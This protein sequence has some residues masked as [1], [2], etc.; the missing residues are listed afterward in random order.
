LPAGLAISC[1][2]SALLGL[3]GDLRGTLALHWPWPAAVDITGR[4]LGEENDY[5]VEEVADA[6]AEIVNMVAGGIKTAF[7]TEGKTLELA[8]PST[9]TGRSFTV[10]SSRS[11]EH[12]VVPFKMA[13]GEFWVELK[14]LSASR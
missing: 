6:M 14:F 5:P 13:K 7:G 12:L 1:G 8:V 4:L 2:L 3:A 11:V 9:V 10:R